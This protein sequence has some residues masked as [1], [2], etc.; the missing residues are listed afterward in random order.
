MAVQQFRA[1]CGTFFQSL[2]P[3][4]RKILV[5]GEGREEHPPIML[6]G[7]APGEQETL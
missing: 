4:E 3:A 1:R 7:E 6:I 2:W 5:Y